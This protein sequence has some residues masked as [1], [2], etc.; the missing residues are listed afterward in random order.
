MVKSEGEQRKSDG[1]VVPLSKFRAIDSYIVRRLRSVLIKKRG[2]NLHAG[3]ADQWTEDWF[4]QQG[5][6][7]LRGTIRYPKAA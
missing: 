1:V 6:Y 2:R 5:L 7:R 3:V 4:N